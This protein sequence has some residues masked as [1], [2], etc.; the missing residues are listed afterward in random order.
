MQLAATLIRRNDRFMVSLQRSCCFWV[1]SVID[2]A[3]VRQREKPAEIKNGDVTM[4]CAATRRSVLKTEWDSD[5]TV[6]EDCSD[7]ITDD[8]DIVFIVENA[9]RR[10]SSRPERHEGTKAAIVTSRDRILISEAFI[11]L[12]TTFHKAFVGRVLRGIGCF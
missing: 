5:G 10:F 1:R 3:K 11:N 7:G 9:S 4:H 2:Q 8:S 12:S 6:T